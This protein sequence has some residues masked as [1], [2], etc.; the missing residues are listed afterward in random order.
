MTRAFRVRAILSDVLMTLVF[1]LTAFAQAQPLPAAP[2]AVVPPLT[3][4]RPGIADSEALVPVGALQLEGGLEL[5]EAPSGSDPRWTQT[6]GELTLRYGV[7]RRIEVFGG[8]DGL[9]LDRAFVDGQS[10]IVAGGNDVLIGTKL[11]LLTEDAHGFTLTIAPSWSF[12]LGAE[13][14]T[15]GSEDPS[16]RVLWAR[17]L[18]RE[19][20]ISGNLLWTRTSDASGRY[21]ETDV[22]AGLTRSLTGTLS[23]FVEGSD[24]TRAG[25]AD[26]WTVDSGLAWVVGLDR[27]LDVS[28]GYTPV[29]HVWFVSAGITLRRR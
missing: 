11:S 20:A 26:S 21:W 23:A 25:H 28:A 12:P 27:Q 14:F 17:S 18:P 29:D 2:Q 19:W 4:N 5:D 13:E 6:W 10:R 8:W 1:P 24:A 22:M 7:A 16:F 15:S 9:S 3:S